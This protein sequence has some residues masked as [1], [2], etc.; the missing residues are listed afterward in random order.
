LVGI[1]SRTGWS[2]DFIVW[3]LSVAN[4][5]LALADEPMTLYNLDEEKEGKSDINTPEKA[6]GKS[7]VYVDDLD[8]E[9]SVNIR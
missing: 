2:W 9:E 8:Y 4:L 3:G 6:F 1:C 5:R 7:V